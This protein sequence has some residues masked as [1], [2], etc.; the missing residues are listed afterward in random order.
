MAKIWRNFTVDQKLIEEFRGKAYEYSLA[1]PDEIDIEDVKNRI[2]SPEDVANNNK[3]SDWM[4]KRILISSHKD[5][6]T[7]MKNFIDFF[8]F[9][10][11]YRVSSFTMENVL[12]KEFFYVR[13]LECYGHDKEGNT[14]FFIRLKYYKKIDQLDDCLKRG[15]V[16]YFEDMDLKYE[17]GEC[18]G[19]LVFLD[20]TDFSVSNINLDMLQFLVRTMPTYYSGLIRNILIHE[21]P[22]L[23]SYLLKVVEGWI[24][25]STDSDG[26]KRKFFHSVNK[27]SV[28]QFLDKD[29]M[30]DYSKNDGSIKAPESTKPFMEIVPYFNIEMKNAVKINEYLLSICN[31][32]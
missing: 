2:S 30:P 14:N 22:F 19:A 26:K 11:Q 13:A 28:T 23:L 16:Y 25:A 1:H 4:L 5:V 18:D 24:P 27:K 6:D 17:R 12:P 15:I 9:R 3:N 29:Q 31:Y 21:I 10:K 7:A 32:G 20:A 8:R